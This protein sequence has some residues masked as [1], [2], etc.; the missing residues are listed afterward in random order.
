MGIEVRLEVREGMGEE[1]SDII[2]PCTKCDKGFTSLV[3]YA[4]LR[5]HIE[6]AF[7]IRFG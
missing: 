7:Y 6:M 2:F 4:I 1:M 5:E 3:P